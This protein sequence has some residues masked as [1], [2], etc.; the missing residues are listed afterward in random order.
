MHNVNYFKY[1]RYQF[2]SST[3]TLI[4]LKHNIL[5]RKKFYLKHDYVLQRNKLQT[6]DYMFGASNARS[7]I[8]LS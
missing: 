5:L 4:L 3:K 1:Q 6:K 8:Q 2:V 7:A